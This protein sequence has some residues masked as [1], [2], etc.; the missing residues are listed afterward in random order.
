MR[1]IL[2]NNGKGNEQNET[3]ISKYGPSPSYV[4]YQFAL[5]TPTRPRT[6]LLS[7]G[8]GGGAAVIARFID[9]Q[10]LPNFALGTGVLDERGRVAEGGKG[11]GCVGAGVF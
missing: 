8:S 11:E 4:I 7:G 6:T 5:P 9:V 2:E 1:S 10:I 3:T